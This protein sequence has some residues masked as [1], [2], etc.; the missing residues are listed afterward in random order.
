MDKK[1]RQFPVGIQD[2]GRIRDEDFVYVDKTEII[3]NLL[4]NSVGAFLSRPRRFGKSLLVSTLKEI[5]SG[6]KR[7][8]EGLWISE[9]DYNWKEYCVIKLDFSRLVSSNTEALSNSLQSMLEGVAIEYGL[10]NVM[11][12]Y[13]SVTLIN[14]VKKYLKR[15]RLLFS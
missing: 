9:S 7:L 1:E 15:K 4:K 8:F 13:P 3:Y 10:T 6:N 14:L 12:D 11:K 5:F 2:F